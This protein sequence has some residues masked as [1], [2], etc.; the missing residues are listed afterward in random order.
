MCNSSF[1]EFQAS[2]EAQT[3][4]QA[5]LQSECLEGESAEMLVYECDYY[6]ECRPGNMYQLTIH[7][8]DWFSN[9]LEKLERILYDKIHP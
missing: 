3:W 9:D 2:R 6:I 7:N 8:H 4:D 5:K 1:K